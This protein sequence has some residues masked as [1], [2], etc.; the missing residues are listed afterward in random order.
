[1]REISVG[2]TASPVPAATF[3]ECVTNTARMQAPLSR[4]RSV[5]H[6]ARKTDTRGRKMQHYR[7]TGTHMRVHG[8]YRNKQ[9]TAAFSIPR[10]HTQTHTYTQYNICTV[11]ELG[12]RE[13][14]KRYS[15]AIISL[16]RS[17]K[18][19]AER[20]LRSKGR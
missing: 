15:L 9:D 4:Q 3:S 8:I 20:P 5:K 1:M 6:L 10:I 13:S 12:H 2:S 18:S 11:M 16:K 19:H 14:R 17:R 7:H